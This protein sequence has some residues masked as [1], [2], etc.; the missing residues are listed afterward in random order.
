[1]DGHELFGQLVQASGKRGKFVKFEQGKPLIILW[2]D[3]DWEFARAATHKAWAYEGE[4]SALEVDSEPQHQP[5]QDDEYDLGE[6]SDEYSGDEDDKAERER[7]DAI[8]LKK[9]A[10]ILAACS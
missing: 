5:V 4:A 8:L 10:R 6:S 1:M 3:V 9:C 2:E 7:L